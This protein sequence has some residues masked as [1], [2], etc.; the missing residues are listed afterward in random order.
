MHQSIRVPLMSDVIP[1]PNLPS[2]SQA[3]DVADILRHVHHLLQKQQVVSDMVRRQESH[4]YEEGRRDL[5]QALVARQHEVE[6]SQY[7]GRQHP[8]DLGFLLEN[9]DLDHRK[10]VWRLLR[11]DQ[12]GAVLLEV[13]DAVRESLLHDMEYTDILRATE[14]LD[15]TDIAA[16]IPDLPK[17]IGY[18]LLA[19]L[20]AKER[21]AVQSA[22]LF[23]ADSVGA[24]MELD[25][26]RIHRNAS[27]GEVLEQLRARGNLAHT[28]GYFFVVD[29]GGKF[30][31]LLPVTELLIRGADQR[32]H[33]VMQTDVAC[34]NTRDKAAAAASAFERYDL[35]C[36]PVVNQH[37]HLVGQITVD[38]V[39][40]FLKATSQKEMLSQVGLRED[41]DIF[42]PVL[43]SSR[44]RWAWLALNLVTAFIASRV[45]GAFEGTIEKL[46]ALAALMPIVASI[47]GNTGNQTIALMIRGLTLGQIH[48]GSLR[49]ILLKESG[50]AVINGLMWGSVMGFFA[51]LL[52]QQWGLALVMTMAMTL[53]LIVAALAGVCI[54][55]LLKNLGRDPVMGSSV[56]L[57]AL[58]D[59]MG[60]FI[61]LGLASVLLL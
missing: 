35:V 22:L 24:L 54:P 52:Y 30:E 58:T 34:F 16:L 49:R 12:Q 32:V 56:L 44:N 55:L 11:P 33:E 3:Q 59:S 41:E 27:L 50:I 4:H 9:L 39:V 6:M 31:G 20:E 7:L 57:T 8:A 28:H 42:A 53:N 15:I 43:T 29:D 51:L 18:E 46:V 10:T 36:A 25:V 1:E 45:I 17:E 19:S 40:D 26:Y 21:A 38:S 14:H 13:A 23:P 61:F 47:G 5:V 60:F 2:P 37:H 48:A